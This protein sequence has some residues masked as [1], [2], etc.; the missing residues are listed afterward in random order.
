MVIYFHIFLTVN[1]ILPSIVLYFFT[2]LLH[3]WRELGYMLWSGSAGLVS[4]VVMILISY[5]L[6]L[7]FLH[8]HP[9]PPTNRWCCQIVTLSFRAGETVPTILWNFNLYLFPNYLWILVFFNCINYSRFPFC[10]FPDTIIWVHFTILLFAKGRQ[11]SLT[12][13][14]RWL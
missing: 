6:V 10:N 4:K 14:H 8:I 12:E 2:F 3:I 1:A 13:V 11:N 7:S 5:K 9:T